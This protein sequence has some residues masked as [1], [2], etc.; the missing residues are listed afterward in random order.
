MRPLAI[1]AAGLF[2]GQKYLAGPV[3]VLSENGSVIDVDCS[4][5]LPPEHADLLDLGDL[6]LLPGLVDAHTHLSWE[7]RGNPE[8]LLSE[9][10]E[11]L[12]ARARLH[13]DQ[14][15]SAGITT[16]RDLGSRG[17]D[18]LSLREDYRRGRAVGPELLVSGP[19]ITPSNGHGWFL[20]GVADSLDQVIA[21]VAERARRGVDWVKVMATGGF[22]TQGSDPAR[23]SYDLETMAALVRSAHAHGLPVTAHAHATSG[24]AALVEAGVDG[25]E[26][27][28]FY[29]SRGAVLDSALVEAMADQGIRA[30]I[31]LARP[32]GAP[33]PWI[34]E[35]LDC[36][37]PHAGELMKAGVRVALCTDAGINPARPHDVLPADLVYAADR[38]LTGLQV[39]RAAT[40]VAAEVCGVGHCKG[41]IAPGYD[42]DLIAVS[43]NPLHD[44]RAIL[45]VRAVV[46]AG[47][48]VR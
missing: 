34:Q 27:C 5:V 8:H 6:T 47:Q 12:L 7:P 19:P 10:S 4:G 41:R 39:L 45:G 25:I 17:F 33:E 1:R 13:A 37:V 36:V 42:A 38:G 16:L 30:G 48:R 15:L 43:G 3:L 32:Q 40:S 18:L 28:T 20:G 9:D 44:I 24:I 46:R 2:D 29:T 26:H 23:P 35:I 22:T 21:A 31:T 11:R 14:A